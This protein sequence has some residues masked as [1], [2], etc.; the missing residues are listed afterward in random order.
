MLVLLMVFTKY[1]I[2]MPHMSWY[3]Y[4]VSQR[5]VNAF[6]SCFFWG[7][8]NIRTYR[9]LGDW[10]HT[11]TFVLTC[12]FLNKGESASKNQSL[13][14]KII[15][16]LHRWWTWFS[17][18]ITLLIIRSIELLCKQNAE[19]ILWMCEAWVSGPRNLPNSTRSFAAHGQSGAVTR[20]LSLSCRVN[21]NPFYTA[22]VLVSL[23][24]RHST[25]PRGIR[26]GFRILQNTRHIIINLFQS[27]R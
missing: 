3:T 23:Q 11:P 19:F 8:V 24:L 10:C 13:L 21:E 5:L 20:F 22:L 25:Q 27:V 2:E 26:T 15:P 17:E 14:H 4:Q 12:F 7:G 9:Q 18:I 16:C 1:A 6:K